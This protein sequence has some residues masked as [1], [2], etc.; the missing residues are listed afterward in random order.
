MKDLK[1]LYEFKNNL[2]KIYSLAADMDEI[3]AKKDQFIRESK[4]SDLFYEITSRKSTAWISDELY[5]PISSLDNAGNILGGKRETV[6][7]KVA[8]PPR[9]KMQLLNVYCKSELENPDLKVVYAD[10]TKEILYYF[11]FLSEKYKKGYKVNSY[12]NIIALNKEMFNIELLLRGD[13]ENADIDSITNFKKL[14]NLYQINEMNL[15]NLTTFGDDV[16]NLIVSNEAKSRQFV[17]KING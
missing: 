15:T 16:R 2:L 3:E 1:R 4:M 8:N 5:V 17:K 14:F 12:D 10:K 11:L 6:L 7:S 13:I 9:I